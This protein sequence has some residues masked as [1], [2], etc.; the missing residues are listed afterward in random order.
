MTALLAADLPAPWRRAEWRRLDPVADLDVV[1]QWMHAPHVEPYWQ[2]AL[3]RVALAAYLEAATADSHQDV[4]IGEVD[5]EPASYWEVYWADRDR[6]AAFCSIQPWDQGVHLL[7]GP[8]ELTGRGLGGHLLGALTRWLFDREPATQR[9][10]AEPD[11]GNSRSIGLFARC[12]FHQEA[13][14][15][16]P[17]KHAALM[18]LR[19]PS[20]GSGQPQ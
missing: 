5:G 4:L 16:M 18:V 14:L 20:P 8:A 15:V 7:I 12:G 10:L 13:E 11:V 19:R 9:V 2:L 17:E 6:L 1:H 3:P